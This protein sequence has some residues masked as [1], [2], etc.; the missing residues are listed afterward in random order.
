MFN[1]GIL[2]RICESFPPFSGGFEIETE[3]KVYALTLGL[4]VK[5][6]IAFR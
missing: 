5:S 3:V 6:G 1:P 4:P 2:T